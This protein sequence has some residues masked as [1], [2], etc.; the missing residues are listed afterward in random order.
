VLVDGLGEGRQ[1]WVCL[2]DWKET[3]AGIQRWG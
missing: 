2:G 3:D 1:G